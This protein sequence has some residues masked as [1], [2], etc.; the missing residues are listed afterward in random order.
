MFRRQFVQLIS[1]AGVGGLAAT[2]AE[3]AIETRT[4]T[5]RVKGFSCITCAVGLDAMLQREKGVTWSRSSYPDGI[6]VI[7]YAPREITENALRSYI[8]DMGFTVA[9]APAT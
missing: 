8:T 9:E 5:Y 3:A 1:L 7:N 6:V 2:A 4:V